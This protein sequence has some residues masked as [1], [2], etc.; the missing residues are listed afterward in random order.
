MK[1]TTVF[2][3]LLCFQVSAKTYSQKITV[4]VKEVSLEKFLHLVEA[5]SGYG[6]VYPQEVLANSGRVTLQVTNAPL[7]EVLNKCLSERGLTWTLKNNNIVITKA[8]SNNASLTETLAEVSLQAAAETHDVS[9]VVTDE[10]GQP[11]AG[12]SVSVKGTKLGAVS[13]EKG[14]FVIHNVP[15]G[16]ITVSVALI[17]Y[18][19]FEKSLVVNG[20]ERVFFSLKQVTNN[21]DET[22]IIAYGTTTKRLNTGAVS[23]IGTDA[24]AKQ[25]VSN[26][27]TA[28][29]GRIAGVQ[30]T[31]DNGLSGGGVRMQIRGQG[32][33]NAGFIPLYV[34]DGVPFTLFNGSQP[35]SDNLN[36][37]GISGANG[38]ISPFSM[39]N[40]ENI[41]RID[42]LKDADATAIYGSRGANGV[43]LIT[44]KKG[45][46]GKTG[47]TANVYEGVGKVNHFIPMMNTQ[48]YLQM[49]REAF[50]NAGAT[51]TTTNA[52]DLTV[53]D[54]TAYT[55]WQKW[56]LGGTSH[57]TH[58]SLGVSGGNAQNNIMFN[59]T[60]HRDGT[61]FPGDYHSN[62]FSNHLSAGHLSADN[63][64]SIRFGAEYTYMN[65]N[66]P[67]TDLT[68]YYNLA[69]NQ[70]LYNKN[71]TLNWDMT[72][73]PAA[74]LLKRYATRTDNFL[75]NL[76]ISYK[77]L[78]QLA[79]KANLG[80]TNTRLKQT[81][82][83]PNKAVNS[84]LNTGNT[85]NYADNTNDNFI[86]EPQVEYT[87]KVGPGKLQLL[88]GATFQQNKSTGISE[89]GTGYA[90]DQLIN[91]LQGAASITISSANYSLY[92][93]SAF[94]GRA[95]YN[96]DSKYLFDLTFRRDASSRFGPNNRLANFGAAGAAWVFSQEDFMKD[97]SVISFGKLRASYGI[98]GNDQIPDYQYNALYGTTSTTYTY[99]GTSV[100]VPGNVANPDLKWENN[101]KLDVGLEL[102]FIKDRITFK[103]DYYRNRTSNLLTYLALP[104]QVGSTAYYGNLPA[105]VQNRGFEFE[106]NATP[107]QTKDIRWT[108]TA[109]LT[110]NNNKLLSYPGLASSYYSSTYIIGQPLILTQLYHFTGVDASTGKATFEDVNK[111][112]SITSTNDRFP[113]KVGTPYF[114]GLSTQFT[115]KH[116]TIDAA[117]QFNHRYGYL[118]STLVT[119]YNPWG[120]SYT[121][122]STQV[123]DRWKKTGDKTSLP[124]ATT[125]YDGT[126]STLANSDYNWGDAS[127]VK[128]KTLSI[129]YDV[130]GAWIKRSGFTAIAV[131]VR[132][133][134]L[135]TWAKNKYTLDPE[136]TLSGTGSNL[137]VGTYI[138]YPQ[139]RVLTAGFNLSF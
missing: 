53:W 45:S 135:F 25:T 72:T 114:G 17:G 34:I 52:K 22:V 110:F 20:A 133:Q 84:T 29:Q 49:R 69:P 98:T 44:T 80:Y 42:V 43:V 60:Y 115:Y 132:G 41:E 27:L 96:I 48:Q 16:N 85:F 137:G 67:S 87:P 7:A 131:Y 130:P 26:P 95:N 55:D 63:K 2:M 9:G 50:A 117:F 93:Y 83:T 1:L 122:Q 107:V 74:T 51:P 39:I 68:S 66:L 138:A 19:P 58:A 28:M 6:I 61:V 123:L 12:A 38:G 14:A 31:Q 91:S 124:L 116:F 97:I 71:G 101:K 24:I 113:A 54:T 76:N 70:P 59:S 32:T 23:S 21:L 75:S 127:F 112:G 134:N 77:L 30:I 8:R 102:G 99:T 103:A 47:F 89:T 78:P 129:T 90:S 64:F 18:T 126:Y 109:N 119:N 40:P 4:S 92:K 125:T 86:A 120:Y 5:Q 62:S 65:N 94:F 121:N 118:N 82:A 36:A 128:F 73:N 88:G 56:A 108:V 139:I 79:I 105:V 136:T 10:K 11:L 13:D 104:G 37:Y 3:V 33:V 100:L 35:A 15:D 111:D 106:L 57:T 46:K 81:L